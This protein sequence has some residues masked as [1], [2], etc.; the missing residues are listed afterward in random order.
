MELAIKMILWVLFVFLVIGP[1]LIYAGWRL[2]SLVVPSEPRQRRP[3]PA[4]AAPPPA[5]RPA[6]RAIE[7]AAWQPVAAPGYLRKWDG[8][9]KW[10]VREEKK[11]WDSAFHS[12]EKEPAGPGV[13]RS[14]T[15]APVSGG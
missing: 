13:Y 8:T 4:K 15:A 3:K 7:V 1:I 2:V 11:A 12:A 5:P 10:S 6:P 14:S 9:R